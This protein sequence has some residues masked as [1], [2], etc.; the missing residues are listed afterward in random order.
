MLHAFWIVDTAAYFLDNV[1]YAK[2]TAKY[3]LNTSE[4]SLDTSNAPWI[5]QKIYVPCFK[6]F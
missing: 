4:Y 6:K 3:Y 1:E 2:G 5:P